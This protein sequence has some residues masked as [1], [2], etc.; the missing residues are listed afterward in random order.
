M[1]K[2]RTIHLVSYSEFYFI[3]LKIT[4]LLKIRFG[5]WFLFHTVKLILNFWW[6]KQSLSRVIQTRN[7]PS[8]AVRCH[9][10]M[11]R[12]IHFRGHN[13]QWHT[14]RNIRNR[15]WKLSISWVSSVVQLS[16]NK[17]LW[18]KIL[19]STCWINFREELEG[20]RNRW[21]LFRPGEAEGK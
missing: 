13:L 5:N 3:Q 19:L 1:P 17:L 15:K 4:V 16:E 9:L 7:L 11:I 12:N 2:D 18:K 20:E 14:P 6:Q 10:S 21:S 8:P